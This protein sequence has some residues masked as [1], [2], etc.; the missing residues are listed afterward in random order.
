MLNFGLKR[1]RKYKSYSNEDKI[2]FLNLAETAGKKRAAMIMNISWLTAKTWIKKDETLK[3]EQ[4]T[5]TQQLL[6]NR[7]A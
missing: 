7:S 2:A 6:C 3:Q 5:Y 1:K 4:N